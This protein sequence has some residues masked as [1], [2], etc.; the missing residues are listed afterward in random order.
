MRAL[1][2]IAKPPTNNHTLFYDGKMCECTRISHE[3]C[4]M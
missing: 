2:H 4:D 3:K 1:Y